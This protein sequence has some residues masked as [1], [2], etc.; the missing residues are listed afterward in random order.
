[1]SACGLNSQSFSAFIFNVC[2]FFLNVSSQQMNLPV[3]LS[4][5]TVNDTTY[6]QQQYHQHLATSTQTVS[7]PHLHCTTWNNKASS[8]NLRRPCGLHSLRVLSN[9]LLLISRTLVLTWGLP[10]RP[11][12][13][14]IRILTYIWHHDDLLSVRLCSVKSIVHI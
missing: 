5:W 7:Y 13:K 11:R 2:A 12:L 9:T 6:M 8:V 3:L 10:V 14:I 1:M 4:S